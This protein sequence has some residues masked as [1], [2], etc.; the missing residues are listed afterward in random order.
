[1]YRDYLTL[2]PTRLRI[3]YATIAMEPNAGRTHSKDPEY[4]VRSQLPVLENWVKTHWMFSYTPPLAGA[5]AILQYKAPISSLTLFEQLRIQK[6]VLITPG[7]HFGIRGSYFRVGYGYDVEKLKAGL[8]QIKDF[9]Q[10]VKHKRQDPKRRSAFVS[11]RL[12][13]FAVKSLCCY[14]RGNLEQVQLLLYQTVLVVRTRVF[15]ISRT[16]MRR[17]RKRKNLIVEL[18]IGGYIIANESDGGIRRATRNRC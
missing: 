4:F 8:A 15:T 16:R 2:T 3:A 17:P 13:V 6:S 1:M 12:S 7:I 5:I 10:E 9:F 11:S 14:P 18:I